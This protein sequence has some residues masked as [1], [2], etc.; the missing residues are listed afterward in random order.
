MRVK[1]HIALMFLILQ[2]GVAL[3]SEPSCT[4]LPIPALHPQEVRGYIRGPGRYCLQQDITAV[5]R[6][7]VH[8]GGYKSFAGQGLIRIDCDKNDACVQ[9][10]YSIDLQNRRVRA[11]ATDMVGIIN[12]SGGMDVAIRNGHIEVPGKSSANVAISL[13]WQYTPF[14]VMGKRC[15]LEDPT[16]QDIPASQTDDK[17]AP[18]Y[19][20]GGYLIDNVN[21]RAGWRGVQMGGGGNIL[22]N[23][24]V[25]VDSST[26]AVLF[27]PGAI[28]ENNTIIIHGKGEHGDFDAALKLRDAHG[29]VVRNN[30][31]VYRGG[32]FS[33]APAAIN[34]LDSRDVLIEGN[35]FKGFKL[36]VRANGATT[37]TMK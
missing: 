23:S 26:A 20:P 15:L 24:V 5:S 28:V 4:P 1:L 19:E 25:A 17:R 12:T 14:A 35:T 37:Y 36:P 33:N 3:G 11:K 30:A 31:F 32:L 34:L 29:A 22:R 6:F 13:R 8:A 18:D 7:D 16:C 2:A 27:G 21:V 10:A 9:D